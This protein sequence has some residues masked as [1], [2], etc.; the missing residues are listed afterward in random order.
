MQLYDLGEYGD[1]TKLLVQ[2]EDV[3]RKAELLCRARGMHVE[4]KHLQVCAYREIWLMDGW[5]V[6]LGEGGEASIVRSLWPTS[7]GRP[8]LHTIVV[9]PIIQSN[10]MKRATMIEGPIDQP[11]QSAN[12]TKPHHCLTARMQNR[13]ATASASCRCTWC[14]PPRATS[15]TSSPSPTPVRP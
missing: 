11:N 7:H 15:A 13:R 14:R 1:G 5:M 12:P 2:R 8:V 9:G 4:E 10:D 3:F 6:G